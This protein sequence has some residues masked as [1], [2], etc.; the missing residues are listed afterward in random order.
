MNPPASVVGSPRSVKGAGSFK[1]GCFVS[2]PLR[3]SVPGRP[4][5]EEATELERPRGPRIAALV[6]S[7]APLRPL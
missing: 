1:T 2:L 3:P 5:L 6:G 7:S 4:R